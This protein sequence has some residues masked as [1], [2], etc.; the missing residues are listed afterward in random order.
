[1]HVDRFHRVA[2]VHTLPRRTTSRTA[3]SPPRQ[4]GN[5]RD[6]TATARRRGRSISPRRERV[7]LSVSPPPT[8]RDHEASTAAGALMGYNTRRD[9]EDSRMSPAHDIGC[10]HPLTARG[11]PRSDQGRSERAKL[12]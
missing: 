10:T 1:M 11:G 12:W 6:D 3:P 9:A 7:D 4:P 5:P 2:D 8:G